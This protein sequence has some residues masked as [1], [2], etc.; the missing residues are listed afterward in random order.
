[1][2]HKKIYDTIVKNASKQNRKK[3]TGVL[4]EYHHIL[5]KSVGGGNSKDNLVLLTPK[6]HYICHRLLVEIYKG[7]ID[8]HKMYYAMWCMVNGLGNQKRYATSSRIYNRLREE[9]IKLNSKERYDNRKPIE[10]YTLEGKYIKTYDSA[11]IASEVAVVSRT[12]I[13][14]CARGESKSA[15][16]FNWRY[17]NSHKVISEVVHEK[18][19]RKTGVPAHNK[20]KKYPPGTR[21]VK[22]KE[23]YQ[24]NLSMDF[25]KKWDTIQQ[26]SDSLQISRSSIENCARKVSK[27]SGGFIWRY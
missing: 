25:I 15:G 1:M 8:E 6:E 13:E 26:A 12:S 5:P 18:S 3:K 10:Q 16:G 7:T 17:T 22:Y 9:L 11:K 24:Y 2:N 4:Y 23:V 14:N 20:G 27:T 19:G 21:N